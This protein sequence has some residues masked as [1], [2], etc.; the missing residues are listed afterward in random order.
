MPLLL[1]RL[2]LSF[3]EGKVDIASASAKINYAIDNPKLIVPML[4]IEETPRAS[5]NVVLIMSY[6]LKHV[7]WERSNKKCMMIVRNSIIEY[8]GGAIT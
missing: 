5:N 8:I 3:L 2:Q 4:A 7:N 6:D 1:L